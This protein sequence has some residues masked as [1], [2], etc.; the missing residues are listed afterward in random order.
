V[1]RAGGEGQQQSARVLQVVTSRHLAGRSACPGSGAEAKIKSSQAY[2]ESEHWGRENS[3]AS[4]SPVV[5][6]EGSGEA[7][8]KVKIWLRIFALGRY[9]F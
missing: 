4:F 2:A 8:V 7:A 9:M 5:A 6:P 3:E 1:L